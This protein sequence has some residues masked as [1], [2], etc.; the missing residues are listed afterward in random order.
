MIRARRT[1]LC[2]AVACVKAAPSTVWNGHRANRTKCYPASTKLN[3]QQSGSRYNEV[4]D[5]LPQFAE[6]EATSRWSVPIAA[7][8]AALR[9]RV[10]GSRTKFRSQ[11]LGKPVRR[12]CVSTAV[13]GLQPVRM[14]SNIGSASCIR[15]GPVLL[16]PAATPP[17]KSCRT[18]L[19][20]V[21]P[22]TPMDAGIP[23]R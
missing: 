11:V 1:I 5:I 16:R 15:N 4:S 17:T 13:I 20:Q 3:S 19:P 18:R 6:S 21:P 7:R 22:W 12:T 23:S 2:K 8:G 10:L 14:P 9:T